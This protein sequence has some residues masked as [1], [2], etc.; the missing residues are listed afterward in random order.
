MTFTLLYYDSLMLL[1]D[2]HTGVFGSCLLLLNDIV[3]ASAATSGYANL[4]MPS[5]LPFSR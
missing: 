2:V 3:Q 4:P 5:S 1:D